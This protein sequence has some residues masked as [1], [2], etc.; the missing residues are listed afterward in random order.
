VG[1]I[2]CQWAKI[3]G[4][5]VIGTVSSD[6]KAEVA[7]AHGCDHTIN[8]RRE[9]FRQARARADGGEG[10]PVVIDSVGK[11]TFAGSLDSLKRRGLLV[12][13]GTASGPFR[14]S[15]RCSSR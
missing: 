4:L 2:V 12:G 10:V 13:V 8:Y 7:R 5:N 15:T 11:D 9:D 1:L 14:P 6:E 3:L